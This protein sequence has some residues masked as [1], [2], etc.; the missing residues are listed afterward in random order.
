MAKAT[1]TAPSPGNRKTSPKK[2]YEIAIRSI[3]AN[4]NPRNPLSEE[5]QKLGWDVFTG[6]KR[7]W[8]L[9]VSDKVSDRAEFVK[10]LREHDDEIVAIATTILTQGLLEPVE[11]RESGSGTYTLVFGCRR[12]LATLFNWCMLGRPK[13]PIIQAFLVKGNS[14]QLLHRAVIENIR[15]APTEIE[16]AKAM[17]MALNNGETKE[18]IAKGYGCSQ[19]TVENRLKLLLLEPAVQK[20]IHDG[21]MK[22]SRALAESNGQPAKPKVRSR[23]VL[24]QA[25]DEYA[26]STLERRVLDWVLCRTETI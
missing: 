16:E 18:E 11:V 23:K 21:S 20:K 1:A 19:G 10:L 12:C 4:T 9:A 26:A 3:T 17:Q 6:D 5:L 8:N 22:A 14:N 25:A 15:K 24:E 2:L 13:V 7:L